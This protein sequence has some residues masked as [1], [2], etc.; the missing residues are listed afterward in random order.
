MRPKRQLGVV[1]IDT[2]RTFSLSGVV[3]PSSPVSPK[4][5]DAVAVPISSLSG[6]D[7]HRTLFFDLLSSSDS[8]VFAGAADNDRFD[9]LD[10]IA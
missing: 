2:R 1:E 4:S 9:A 6:L 3:L 5:S 10:L 8:P 7:S